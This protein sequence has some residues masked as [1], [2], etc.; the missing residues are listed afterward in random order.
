MAKARQ[1]VGG[2][3]RVQVKQ[4]SKCGGFGHRADYANCL[5]FGA[6]RGEDNPAPRWSQRQKKTATLSESARP[7]S[8]FDPRLRTSAARGKVFSR[9]LKHFW[10]KRKANP[11]YAPKCTREVSPGRRAQKRICLR[12]TERVQTVLEG[13]ERAALERL[14]SFGFLYKWAGERCQREGC[15]GVYSMLFQFLVGEV[16]WQIP[17]LFSLLA[18]LE[19]P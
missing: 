12:S 4:C 11:E 14:V 8:S 18:G 16:P 9:I 6:P 13:T 5:L 15:R 17:P 10:L 7:A 3:K 1:R 19:V 2:K